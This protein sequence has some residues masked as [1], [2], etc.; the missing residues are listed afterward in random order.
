M[1]HRE[2]LEEFFLEAFPTLIE[3]GAQMKTPC[4]LLLRTDQLQMILCF[5]ISPRARIVTASISTSVERTQ[6]AKLN[7][8][9][10]PHD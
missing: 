5:S 8:Y 1:E 3:S 4:R 7:Y 10:R 9:N 6:S 2:L